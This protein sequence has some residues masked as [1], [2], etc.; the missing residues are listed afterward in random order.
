MEWPK[1]IGP[2]PFFLVQAEM[3]VRVE[4]YFQWLPVHAPEQAM[5]GVLPHVQ[6]LGW[7][8]P[9]TKRESPQRLETLAWL[10]CS[11]SLEQPGEKTFVWAGPAVMQRTEP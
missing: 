11:W 2:L 10:C 1:M 8:I 6:G 9:L 7:V 3:Q 5:L 4:G